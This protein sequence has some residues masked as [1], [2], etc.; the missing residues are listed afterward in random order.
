MPAAVV[1]AVAS[2]ACLAEA[3]GLGDARSL[4]TLADSLMRAQMAENHVPGGVLVV[5][6]GGSIV[7]ARGY[8][9][10]DLEHRT[11]VDPART[12]FRAA[13]VS[14]L[15]TATAAMQMVERGRL[16]LDEDVNRHLRRFQVESTY[17]EPVMLLHLLTHT[18]GFDD[19]NIDRKARTPAGVE[20]L[21]AYLARRL[22]PRLMPPGRTLCYSNHGMALAGYLVEEASG[23]PFDRYL[24][25]HVFVPLGMSRSSFGLEPVAPHDLAL[26]YDDS[27]PP[28]PLPVE[29]V[30][31]VPAS[32]LTTTGVDMAR[33]MIAHLQNGRIGDARILGERAAE[34][35]HRRQ[36]AQHPLLSGIALGFWE[37]FQNGERALWH[38]GD[39]GGFTSLLYLLPERNTGFFIV[40]N[41]RGGGTAREEVLAALLDRYFPDQRPSAPPQRFA[42]AARELERCA[43]TYVFNRYGHG[44]LER[45]VSLT[46]QVQARPDSGGTL[47]FRGRRYVPIAPLVFQR[48]DGRGYLIF[49]SDARGRVRHAFTGDP[50]ARVY[51]RVPGYE[52]SL[53]QLAIVGFCVAVF[54]ATLLAWPAA[55]VLG[56]FRAPRP[57]SGLE[58]RAGAAATLLGALN[59]VFLIGLSFFVLGFSTRLVYGAP[60]PFLLV[61]VLPLLGGAILV[62]LVTWCARLWNDRSVP[63]G[64][65]LRLSLVALTSLGFVAWLAQWNLL[66]F[67]F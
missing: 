67:R 41:G 13:S 48:L 19:R 5:V 26:G 64:S 65:R 3:R 34:E 4:E 54:L 22:P 12:I 47:R 8:G 1:V 59:L 7:L 30:K 25:D 46:S 23:E 55:A 17:R 38:D 57:R 18:A 63:L 24:R 49:Q 45:L 31:T 6:Q 60:V 53:V 66:G 35:M 2:M 36:F 37:R 61:L 32:M 21:G 50:I 58:R 52:T 62:A 43:G 51:E 33:F 11:P 28:R 9:Y 40:F 14:K 16:A 20:S 15:F 27:D 44:S 39:G 42:A 29:Y 56:R 10:A